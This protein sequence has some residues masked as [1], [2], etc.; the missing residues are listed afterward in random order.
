VLSFERLSALKYS[1]L[2]PHPEVRLAK[3]SQLLSPFVDDAEGRSHDASHANRAV[4][5]INRKKRSHRL[6]FP[7]PPR[8]WPGLPLVSLKY[9]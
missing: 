6:P 1:S 4:I 2:R 9:S 3:A 5:Q 7:P 8:P